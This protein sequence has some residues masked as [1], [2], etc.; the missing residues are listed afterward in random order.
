[1]LC[2]IKPQLPIPESR[3]ASF[4]N[5]IASRASM[6]SHTLF[7]PMRAFAS[8][9]L[10]QSSER[11]PVFGPVFGCGHGI[12]QSRSPPPIQ[13]IGMISPYLLVIPIPWNGLGVIATQDIKPTTLLPQD[14]A[15]CIIHG[16]QGDVMD[17]VQLV[18]GRRI[19]QA[20]KWGPGSISVVPWRPTTLS[21]TT[22]ANLQD[23]CFPMA[24]WAEK[25]RQH[26]HMLY[27][28]PPQPLLRLQC[29]I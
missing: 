26:L 3:S 19:Q 24:G 27:S 14:P 15:R 20:E 10:L 9:P 13:I 12:S 5:F 2:N 6:A 16:Y 29:H 11:A 21:N 25:G 8:H 28:F 4:L 18:E 22:Y 7:N 1:M 17:V 23:K